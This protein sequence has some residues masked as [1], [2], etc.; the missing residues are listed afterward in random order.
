[1]TLDAAANASDHD[2]ACDAKTRKLLAEAQRRD[3]CAGFA[4]HRGD[5]GQRIR[6]AKIA[7][8]S[9]GTDDSFDEV[10]GGF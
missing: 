9:D 4:K 6:A 2:F 10:I 8:E 1:M 7:F 5:G 3:H